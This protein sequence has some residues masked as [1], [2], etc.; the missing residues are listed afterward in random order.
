[1]TESGNVDTDQLQVRLA[2]IEDLV[3]VIERLREIFLGIRLEWNPARQSVRIPC[4][5]VESIQPLRLFFNL[6]EGRGMGVQ[7]GACIEERVPENPAAARCV[8]A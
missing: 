4:R 6:H 3:E 2:G 8:K 1:M 5:D 7:L